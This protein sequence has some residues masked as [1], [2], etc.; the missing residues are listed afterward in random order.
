MKRGY[1]P[2]WSRGGFTSCSWGA[3]SASTAPRWQAPR[4]SRQGTGSRSCSRMPV[5]GGSARGPCSRC[6]LNLPT[7]ERRLRPPP[8]AGGSPAR[9]PE[10]LNNLPPRRPRRRPRRRT[11]RRL[12]LSGCG[13][14]TRGSSP[15][16]VSNARTL[17]FRA[18]LEGRSFICYFLVLQFC[19]LFPPSCQSKP[20]VLSTFSSPPPPPFFFVRAC[21]SL[22]SSWLTPSSWLPSR[23]RRRRRRN[24]PWNWSQRPSGAT[25]FS[26]S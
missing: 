22:G 4:F 8:T 10:P 6:T 7:W 23:A 13:W 17:D 3:P 15:R 9:S 26:N 21:Q 2:T 16:M 24:W 11:F 18:I 14:C 12:E 1:G 20:C 19:A 25:S 5:P